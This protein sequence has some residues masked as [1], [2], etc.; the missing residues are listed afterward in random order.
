MKDIKQI[1]H[2]QGVLAIICIL[3]FLC[4]PA[5][6]ILALLLYINGYGRG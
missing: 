2:E 1:E 6:W 4:P 3:G 5:G